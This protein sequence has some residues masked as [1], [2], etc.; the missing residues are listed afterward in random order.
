MGRWVVLCEREVLHSLP[1]HPPPPPPPPAVVHRRFACPRPRPVPRSRS[2][3]SPLP[4]VD[5]VLCTL[6][7]LSAC[8]DAHTRGCPDP[9]L[10][11]PPFP[12]RQVET[13]VNWIYG[14][15]VFVDPTTPEAEVALRFPSAVV[16]R[17]DVCGVPWRT[18]STTVDAE[19]HPFLLRAP[20]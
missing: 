15:P 5:A 9:S 7:A 4:C 18:L 8:S 6:C 20:P 2:Q 1:G 10:P 13:P 19:E 16:T 11:P 14:D 12:L 3:S 17:R